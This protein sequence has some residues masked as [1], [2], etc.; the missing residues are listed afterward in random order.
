M[1]LQ[2]SQM[3]LEGFSGSIHIGFGV[4]LSVATLAIL[5]L[6]IGVILLRRK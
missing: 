6:L 3:L 1:K 2:L 5:A 4:L